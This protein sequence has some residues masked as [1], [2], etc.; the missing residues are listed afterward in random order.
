MKTLI[1]G[2]MPTFLAGSHDPARADDDAGIFYGNGMIAIDA[3]T[4]DT[5]RVN[6]LVLEETL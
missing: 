1:C 3:G 4:R 5:H 2:H 6:V